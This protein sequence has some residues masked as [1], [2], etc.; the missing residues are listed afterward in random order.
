MFIRP[1]LAKA[2]LVQLGL[3]FR[4]GKIVVSSALEEAVW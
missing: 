2:R 3:D 1:M 4:N